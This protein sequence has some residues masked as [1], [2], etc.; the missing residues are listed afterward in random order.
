MT[1]PKNNPKN[2][3]IKREYLIWLKEAKQRSDAT[4]EQARH[5]IDRLEGY[6]GFRDF[7]TFNKE[8]AIGFKHTLLESNAKRSGKP[9]SISTVHHTLQAIKEF[10]AWLHG[11]DEY[12]RRII[13]ANIAYLNLTT[14]EERQAHATG[15]K[16]YAT[17]EA[18]RKALFAMPTGTDMECRDQAMMALM[19]LT[20]MRDAAVVSLK[21]KHI[22]VARRRVFQD[23]RQV[24]T[25]FRKT[26]ETVFYPVGEDVEA[27]ITQ[28]VAFLVNEKQFSPDD[29]LFPKTVNG[30][31]AHK[32]FIPAG[33][34]RE[35][36]ANATPVRKIFKTAF[37][38]VG[39]PYV[40]PHSI[41]DTLTQLAYRL[42]LNGEQLKAWSQNMGHDSPLTTLNSYGHVTIE[43]QA[44]IISGLGNPLPSA[45]PMDDMAEKIAEKVLARLGKAP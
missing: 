26:I 43:R 19:L 11:R 8:Q 18:Y 31:D 1:P 36:W 42:K 22:D 37:E 13:P 2:D 5:A 33:L 10:L 29:P 20:C 41:R 14:G 24:K 35:P 44:E 38:R 7:G 21:L 12:R 27:I 28:W 32:H 16:Q 45:A 30:H 25:K 15:Q 6:T 9:I 3:R 39:L 34:G 40:K 23:P 17:L 4:V